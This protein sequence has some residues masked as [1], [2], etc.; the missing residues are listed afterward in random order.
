MYVSQNI[1]ERSSEIPKEIVETIIAHIQP[2]F[3]SIRS[4][5]CVNKFMAKYA[6]DFINKY[7]WSIIVPKILESRII[8]FSNRSQ[9]LPYDFFVSKRQNSFESIVVNNINHTDASYYKALMHFVAKSPRLL[10]LKLTGRFLP[11]LID[12]SFFKNISQNCHLKSV[13]GQHLILAPLQDFHNLHK[14]LHVVS[15]RHYFSGPADM[16]GIL[17]LQAVLFVKSGKVYYCDCQ[18]R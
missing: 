16:M 17:F 14:T 8:N 2:D 1:S 5:A 12:V 13:F 18:G 7:V 15:P 11:N 4:F 6:K 9:S 3:R 10:S